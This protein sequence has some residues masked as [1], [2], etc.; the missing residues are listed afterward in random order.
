MDHIPT[1]VIDPSPALEL[2][3]QEAFAL[4]QEHLDWWHRS[5]VPATTLSL[6]WS[7][8]VA[9]VQFHPAGRWVPSG[10]GDFAFIFMAGWTDTFDVAAWCP[11]T[12]RVTT[13]LGLGALIG[14]EH[15][16][17]EDAGTPIRS[18]RVSTLRL[19]GSLAVVR[20]SSSS[21]GNA[22]ATFSAIVVCWCRTR[23]R[24]SVSS[25][26]SDCRPRAFVWLAAPLSGGP[27]WA[28]SSVGR[29][30]FHR[31]PQTGL[32]PGTGLIRIQRS[33]GG[34][35]RHHSYLATRFLGNE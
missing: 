18:L 33:V 2:F 28:T 6:P 30:I 12:G 1:T 35:R 22:L 17:W 5:G 16:E 11:K 20:E 26:R 14:E 31:T 32:S 21:T 24:R 3:L 19:I 9:H 34:E 13:R 10:L 4:Q 8:K 15:L 29:T 23:S 27:R 7:V 25:E